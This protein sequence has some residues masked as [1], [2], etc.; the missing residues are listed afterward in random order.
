MAVP[1]VA[2]SFEITAAHVCAVPFQVP[3]LKPMVTVES[4]ARLTMVARIGP[5]LVTLKGSVL[6]PFCVSVPTNV[7]VTGLT[8]CDGIAGL[9][10]S[11]HAT[12]PSAIARMTAGKSFVD[13]VSAEFTMFDVG[14]GRMVCRT[15]ERTTAEPG[16]NVE[17]PGILID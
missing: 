10:S 4:G 6:A 7:S 12:C 5:E 3:R 16:R 9:M 17:R 11:E 8:G 1:T 2:L 13:M 14:P 15:A